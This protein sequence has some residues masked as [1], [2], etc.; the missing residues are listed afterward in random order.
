M[1]GPEPPYRSRRRKPG[2]SHLTAAAKVP[3]KGF[4]YYAVAVAALGGL[5]FGYD[6]GVKALAPEA[7]LREGDGLSAVSWSFYILKGDSRSL[8]SAALRS[9]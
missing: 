5:L 4:V 9:G 1:G 2:E 3:V 7:A 8:H 6:T